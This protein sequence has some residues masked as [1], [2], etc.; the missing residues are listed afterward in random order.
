VPRYLLDTNALSRL[1]SGRNPEIGE[2]VRRHR[3]DCVLSAI[4]WYEL[5]Y[6]RLRSPDLV[7]TAA[8][9]ALLRAVFP[10]VQP[11]G[12]REASRA[13]SVRAYLE[14][15]KPN[16]LPV[17]PYDVL[18]AGH[19]L[20]LGAVLVTANVREFLRVPGLTIEN[21]QGT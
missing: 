11:F 13:A 19:A 5:E 2:K 7:R 16:A 12:E 1:V 3:P 18:L 10:D 15:L 9:L 14:A 6:G 8:R 21:W 4:S 17:G 20:E